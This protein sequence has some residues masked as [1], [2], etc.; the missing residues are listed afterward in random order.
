MSISDIKKLIKENPGCWLYTN[1]FRKDVIYLFK[2]LPDGMKINN[3]DDECDVL[4]WC[5]DNCIYE[6][7]NRKECLYLIYAISEI[8]GIKY[9]II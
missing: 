2:K 9:D 6:A 7:K 3:Y 8:A 4:D 5:Y 1:N